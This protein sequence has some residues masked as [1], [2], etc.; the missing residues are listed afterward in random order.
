[1]KKIIYLLAFVLTSSICEAQILASQN[2]NTDLGW[3]TNEIGWARRVAGTSPTCANFEGAGMARFN[4]FDLALGATAKL[5]S[6]VITFDG[7]I[8]RV[9]FKM[10]RDDG[11]PTDADN[12]KVYFSTTATAGGT[13]LGNVNRSISL[14]PIVDSNG[15]YSYSFNVP[16]GTIGTG[17]IYFLGTGAYGNNIFIDDVVIDRVPSIDVEL[18]SII[19]N[20]IVLNG[21]LPITG[22]LKNNGTTTINTLDLNWQIGSGNIYTQ[23]LT[24]LNLAS[25]NS[26]S[27]NHA[28]QWIATTGE[29]SIKVW[30]SNINSGSVDAEIT[31]NQLIKKVTT[32]SQATTRFPLY[33]KFSSATCPPCATFNTNFFSP[34]YNT[35]TNKD[36]FALISYQVNWPG[37]GDPYYTPEIGTRVQY[38]GINAAPT[39]LIDA[40]P[41]TDFSVASLQSN[42]SSSTAKPAYMNINANL[43]LVGSNITINVNT[44]PFVTGEYKLYV[45]VVEK[46]TTGN[47]A[48][49]GETSFKNVFMKMLPD[50]SGTILNLVDGVAVN[51]TLQANLAGLFIE[52][53]SDL[54]VIVFIQ[55]VSNKTIMQSAVASN[56]LSN[57]T[58]DSVISKVKLYPNPSTGIVKIDTINTLSIVLTDVLGKIVLT[59]NELN[60]DSQLNLS[61]LQKG[62]YFAKINDGTTSKIQKII[63]E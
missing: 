56:P 34:F 50:G 38:Y 26:Y 5:I 23:A 33:E 13:L 18:S 17:Y 57:S 59:A 25:G 27:Y 24:G 48:S 30:V 19:M 45:A 37:S 61:N 9:R 53:L 1:M 51:T 49:N 8:N 28:N 22:S 62:I 55:K 4:S 43:T 52:E 3:T 10:Y 32:A 41:G 6:P 36:N 39:L 58:F 12:L 15:W 42:L 11:Y 54:K 7:E 20:P 63:L 47:V 21:S 31:N 44:T 29:Y 46:V 60:K 40:K 16:T 2:F 14:A 35:G